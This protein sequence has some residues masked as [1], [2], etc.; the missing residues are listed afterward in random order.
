MHI[1]YL[2]LRIRNRHMLEIVQHLLCA[3]GTLFC[4][5][6]YTKHEF[7][8]VLVVGH[9]TKRTVDKGK[10]W[11]VWEESIKRRKCVYSVGHFFCFSPLLQRRIGNRTL[12]ITACVKPCLSG[13]G[14][15]VCFIT[16]GLTVSPL[17]RYT[18]RLPFLRCSGPPTSPPVLLCVHGAGKGPPAAPPRPQPPPQRKPPEG[19]R[20]PG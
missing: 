6:C 14:A 12:L 9:D 20:T 10:A 15:A 19:S 5:V 18:Y 17:L 7:F 4:L 2:L 13:S 16:T 11:V 8:L 1:S 3:V